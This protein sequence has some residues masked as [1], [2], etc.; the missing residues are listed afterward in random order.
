MSILLHPL[1]LP[2]MIASIG[3]VIVWPYVLEVVHKDANLNGMR[4]TRNQQRGGQESNAC[5]IIGSTLSNA[6]RIFK[7][8]F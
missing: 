3:I 6:E 5:A 7:P 4:V 8:V 1:D 2:V